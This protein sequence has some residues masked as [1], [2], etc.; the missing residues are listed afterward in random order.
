[1]GGHYQHMP[2]SQTTGER[3][4]KG[5]SHRHIEECVRTLKHFRG[6]SVISWRA[7]DFHFFDCLT[8]F[9][10]VW[11]SSQSKSSRTELVSIFRHTRSATGVPRF[12]SELCF[13]V[14]GFGGAL[15]WVRRFWLSRTLGFGYYP[16]EIL[17]TYAP[18]PKPSPHPWGESFKNSLRK[19]T[20]PPQHL[21]H[22]NDLSSPE[23]QTLDNHRKNIR[24][25]MGIF[26]LY[27]YLHMYTHLLIFICQCALP[28][29]AFCEAPFRTFL[30][31]AV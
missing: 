27:L 18:N 30:E 23:A 7:S 8:N 24:M 2:E 13:G 31:E 22:R 20:E 16:T 3:H 21:Q 19:E 9:M 26:I 4:R 11:Y 14:P 25:C 17:K 15:L 28:K 12:A 6:D 5:L 10:C 29:A 1:M